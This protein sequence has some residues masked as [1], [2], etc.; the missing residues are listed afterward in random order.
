M[1]VAASYRLMLR[2]DA[3]R[4]VETKI[5]AG[6]RKGVEST[7]KRAKEL[8]QH[9][10]PVRSGELQGSIDYQIQELD[11]AIKGI[12]YAGA[13]HAG[14]VEFGTGIKGAGTYPGPLPQAGVPIT[15]SWIYDYK[16][17]NWIGMPAHPYM[18]PAYE[19][20]RGEMKEIVRSEVMA[21]LS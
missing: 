17:Q 14:F 16:K 6:V 18:R 5:R 20:V 8:A 3:G 15:G 2:A 9:H 1:I 10:C 12:V 21:E 19:E 11:K 13:E 4:F 7:C